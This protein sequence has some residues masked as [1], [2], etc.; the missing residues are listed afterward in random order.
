MSLT[1]RAGLSFAC[2]F[3]GSGGLGADFA[4]AGAGFGGGGGGGDFLD[5]DFLDLDLEDFLGA[6]ADFSGAGAGAL[7]SDSDAK[8]L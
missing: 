1:T 6:G 4:A 3:G 8:L 7:G 5:S 2:V